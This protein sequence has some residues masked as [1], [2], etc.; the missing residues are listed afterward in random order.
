VF[1]NQ[2]TTPIRT[3]ANHTD[4]MAATATTP[5]DL[6]LQQPCSFSGDRS[7]TK[8]ELAPREFLQEIL[9]RKAKGSWTEE[10]TMSYISGSLKG[11]AQTWFCD[12]MAFRL[13]NDEAYKKFTTN[14]KVFK[15]EYCKEFGLHDGEQSRSHR[16]FA[17]QQA[18]ESPTEFVDR[19]CSRANS[20]IKYAHI[21]IDISTECPFTPDMFDVTSTSASMQA[22]TLA[23]ARKY[24]L[25]IIQKSAR[26]VASEYIRTAVADGLADRELR[27]QVYMLLEE[28]KTVQEVI[29]YIVA[30]M[31][32]SK[33]ASSGSAQT[34][35]G[36][37]G[38]AQIARVDEGSADE[39]SDAQATEK[40]S[41]KRMPKK[42]KQ[43]KKP[44]AGAVS[45]NSQQQQPKY[46]ARSDGG[47]SDRT[48][49]RLCAYCK[50]PG[51]SITT[52]YI[53]RFNDENNCGSPSSGISRVD[54]VVASSQISA[55]AGAVGNLASMD[56]NALQALHRM[57]SDA[58]NKT[59]GNKNGDVCELTKYAAHS[60]GGDSDRTRRRFCAYCKKPGHSITTCYIKRFNNENNCGPPSSGTPRV[61][62]VVASS[63]ISAPA[64]AVGNLANMDKDALQALHRMTSDALNKAPGNENGDVW[65]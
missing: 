52:C 48:R 35:H 59:P 49:R 7:C 50:K 23:W 13:G 16:N 62:P 26:A 24:K 29:A 64:S 8:G 14:F 40:V 18:D 58:L 60:D 31:H 20:A 9:R 37:E 39:E 34:K 57:T 3:D 36:T 21:E 43:K 51:H 33:Y 15:K 61:D 25:A 44:A 17:A 38:R 42:N 12:G 46:A 4:D 10:K 5:V 55:P 63:Q 2:R 32:S 53:K 19:V 47:D 22:A 6:D 27:K 28:D 65:M 56:K 1:K 11:K 41:A 45:S 54:P 30:H